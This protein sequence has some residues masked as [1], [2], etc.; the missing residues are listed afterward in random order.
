MLELFPSLIRPSLSI[1]TPAALVYPPLP[2]LSPSWRVFLFSD[3]SPSRVIR[4]LSGSPLLPTVIAHTRED[5]ESACDAHAPAGAVEH[6]SAPRLKR[7]VWLDTASGSRVGFATSWWAESDAAV[8]LPRAGEPIGSA[9]AARGVGVHREL[10]LV[11]RGVAVGALA[12]GLR[13]AAGSG[14]GEGGGASQH[15]QLSSSPSLP[16]DTH[17]ADAPQCASEG[18]APLSVWSRWYLMS[19]S[20][21]PL[22]PGGTPRPLALIW[23]VFASHALH[24]LLGVEGDVV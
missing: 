19:V 22:A 7:S 11:E 10:L 18:D 23:E 20:D 21:H 14:G 2:C 15:E 13:G 16:I 4:L 3:A 8:H 9:L 17:P 6:I 24:D 5:A 1:S 12:C